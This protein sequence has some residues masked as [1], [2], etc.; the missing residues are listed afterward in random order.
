MT[1]FFESESF[2]LPSE[3]KNDVAGRL[4]DSKGITSVE[5]QMKGDSMEGGREFS[6]LLLALKKKGVKISHE[7][8]IKLDFPKGISRDS[9]LDIVENMPKPKN[10]S[11]KVRLGLNIKDSDKS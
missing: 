8:S 11:L 1:N 2:V 5:M 10:G 7:F 6:R 4:K 3:V 9:A